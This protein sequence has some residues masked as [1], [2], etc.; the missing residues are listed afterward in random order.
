MAIN[1]DLRNSFGY[2]VNDICMGEGS[3]HNLNQA[4]FWCNLY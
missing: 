1:I 2:M 3:S 4:G